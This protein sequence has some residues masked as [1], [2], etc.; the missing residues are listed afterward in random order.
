MADGVLCQS[1]R[2][3]DTNCERAEKDDEKFPEDRA[4]N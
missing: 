3:K 2:S 1:Q 4:P